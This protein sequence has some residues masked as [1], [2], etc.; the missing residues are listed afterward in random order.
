MDWG[1]EI[2][3]GIVTEYCCKMFDIRN[4]CKIIVQWLKNT[5]IMLNLKSIAKLLLFRSLKKSLSTGEVAFCL[6]FWFIVT[7]SILNL[8]C[9]NV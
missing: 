1:K 8:D 2:S 4:F 6:D 3:K 9:L 5:V 7:K